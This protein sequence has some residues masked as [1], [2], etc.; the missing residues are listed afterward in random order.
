V[1]VLLAAGV[2]VSRLA[3]GTGHTAAAASAGGLA[4]PPSRA[5]VGARPAVAASGPRILFGLGPEADGARAGTLARAAPLGMLSSWYNG[6]GDL[7]WMTGWKNTEVAHDYA[8]GYAMHLIVWSGGPQTKVPTRYGLACGQ[9]YPLSAQ[10]L[11]D[12][13]LLARTFAP[14]RGRRFYVTLFTEFQTYACHGNEWSAEPATTAYFR[15]LKDQYRA[16]LAIFHRLAPGSAV[17]LGWGGWQARWDNPGAG[18]G[19]SLFKHFADVMKLS[20]F[21]S[22][23]VINSSAATSDISGMTRGLGRYGPVMLA[24]FRPKEDSTQVSVLGSVLDRS[25]LQQMAGLR[26]FAIGFMD[27]RF[28]AS[29]PSSF[30]TVRDAIRQYGCTACGP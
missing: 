26:L 17:S 19:R 7:S 14:P 21:E 1:L 25:F 13:R 24:Y 11:H 30:L 22:F 27:E 6:P 16:T 23:E 5:L 10:F 3:D 29:E 2:S 18:G 12:M 8:A 4:G 28:I 20:D 9:A 15:A